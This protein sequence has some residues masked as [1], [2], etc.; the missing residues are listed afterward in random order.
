MEESATG[1]FAGAVLAVFLVALASFGLR[2]ERY[3]AS[4]QCR[5][6]CPRF[7]TEVECELVQEL[8]TGQWKELRSCSRFSRLEDVDCD[9]EC[10]RLLNLGF[11]LD[12]WQQRTSGLWRAHPSA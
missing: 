7:G 10:A 5:F 12:S 9:P 4:Q 8:R 2:R 11:S 3:R 1:L 6:A